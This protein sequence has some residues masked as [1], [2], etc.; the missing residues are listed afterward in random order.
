MKRAIW[1]YGVSNPHETVQ[2]CKELGITDILWGATGNQKFIDAAHKEGMRVHAMCLQDTFYTYKHDTAIEAIKP[3]LDSGL[4]GIH[5]DTEFWSIPKWDQKGMHGQFLRLLEKIRR[6]KGDIPLSAAIT[7]WID[8][9]EINQLLDF[10][11]SMDYFDAPTIP[12]SIVDRHT[13][14]RMTIPT[15][16]GF[17]LGEV[18]NLNEVAETIRRLDATYGNQDNYLGACLFDYRRFME[19]M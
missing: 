13:H 4:D 11:V 2:T 7:W 14:V 17:N 9:T 15:F 5:L 1:L 19:M 18:N 8:T 6:T 10:L 16:A 3:L 12:G